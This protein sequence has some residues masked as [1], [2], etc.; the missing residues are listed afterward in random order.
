MVHIHFSAPYRHVPK[1]MTPHGVVLKQRLAWIDSQNDSRADELPDP[2][3]SRSMG[4][5]KTVLN[6]HHTRFVL[7]IGS[8]FHLNH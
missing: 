6:D 1:A 3:Q 5:R 8:A 7:I 2:P 4:R